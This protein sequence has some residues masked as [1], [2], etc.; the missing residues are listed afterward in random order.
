[1]NN[2]ARRQELESRLKLLTQEFEQQMRARGFDPAQTENVA[3]PTA[4]ARLYGECEMIRE[5]LD[6]IRKGEA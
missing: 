5:Q 2:D 3:L 6:E 1:M 4:L